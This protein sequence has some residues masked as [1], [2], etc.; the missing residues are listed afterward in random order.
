MTDLVRELLK[1]KIP[2][3]LGVTAAVVVVLELLLHQTLYSDI[4][5]D[6]QKAKAQE[7]VLLDGKACYAKRNGEDVPYGGVRGGHVPFERGAG[8]GGERQMTAGWSAGFVFA[9]PVVRG[10]PSAV[11]SR[12]GAARGAASR[13]GKGPAAKTP[14]AEKVPTDPAA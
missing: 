8:G 12:V 7:S 5:V 1:L 14:V 3:K 2:A 10:L 9:V 6:I 11:A 13:A 4:S